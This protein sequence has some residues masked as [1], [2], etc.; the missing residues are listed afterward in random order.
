MTLSDLGKDAMSVLRAVAPTLA[1]AIGGP[2]GGMAA[3]AL[4][5][6]LGTPTSAT[7]STSVQAILANASPSD[8]VKL[9]QAEEAFKQQM[10]DLGIKEEQLVYADIQSARTTMVQSKSI[11]PSILTYVILSAAMTAFLCLMFGI[12]KVP[13]DSNAAVIFGSVLTF[14]FTESKSVIAFWLGS[15]LGSRYKDEAA[16]NE[17][18]SAS[19]PTGTK[20]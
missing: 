14:L 6:V 13:T 10:A 2:F 11:T 12:I 18:L 20:K 4:T 1:T 19:A 8:L 9:K 16:L 5:A 17:S 7:G 3:A 15:S